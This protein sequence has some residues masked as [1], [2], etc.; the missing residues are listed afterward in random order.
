VKAKAAE[1]S[2]IACGITDLQP[3]V[4]RELD[5]WLRHGY[6]GTMRT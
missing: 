2:F 4:R 5:D 3:S 1:L 6:G